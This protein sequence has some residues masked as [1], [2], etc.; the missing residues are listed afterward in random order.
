MV[1]KPKFENVPGIR[2]REAKGGWVA[3]W[4]PR[5]DLVARGYPASPQRLWSGTEPTSDER[6]WIS[7]RCNAM[8][9]EML[10]WSNGGVA[11]AAP[12]I[13]DGTVRSLIGAYQTDPVSTFHKL[14]YGP[15]I[16][17][18]GHC[19]ILAE[20]CG[21]TLIADVDARLVLEWYEV[22][23]KR[24]VSM[25]HGIAGRLRTV[26][27]FGADFLRD[28]EHREQCERVALM[29]H[30]RRFKM[31]KPRTERLTADQAIAIRAM[32]HECG[33]HSIALAQAIQFECMFRQ[34][35]V[36]GEWIPVS[37]P[38]VSD[39]IRGD[40][41][42]MRGIRWQE[43]GPDLILNHTTSKR[44]KDI[45]VDLKHSPM[46]IEELWRL[47]PGFIETNEITKSIIVHRDMLPSN[48]PVIVAETNA[49]PWEPAQFRSSW[50]KIARECKIPDS[51]FNMDTRAG[52]IS[53]ATDAGA[54]LEHVKHAATHS[55]IAM[56]QKY[57]RGADDKIVGVQKTRV[58][59]RNKK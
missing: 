11:Q 30:R 26:I 3:L 56:T 5:T 55:D 14:R 17:A 53:E 54:P 42:W 18:A 46:V 8:Q 15:R 44:E 50:R 36:I 28:K 32:A 22:W 2:L 39:L 59:H 49:R 35:D 24:G 7:D 37:E 33:L 38:G 34:K 21:D 4:R 27:A 43:I 19:K 1:E 47:A 52:A 48:G 12:T 58:E 16:V 31:G 13:F 9:S 57:S 6:Q 41:K 20:D 45:R 25:S 40:Y 10:M 29:L 51:V 23:L